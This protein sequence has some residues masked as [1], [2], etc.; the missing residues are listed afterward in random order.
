[1]SAT[2]LYI[3]ILLAKKKISVTERVCPRPDALGCNGCVTYLSLEHPTGRVQ[4]AAVTLM[5]T[6]QIIT[7]VDLATRELPEN[8]PKHSL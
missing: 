5:V 1:M 3:S 8:P 6:A 4:T 7:G 2:F